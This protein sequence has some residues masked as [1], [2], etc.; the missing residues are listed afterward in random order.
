V[1]VADWLQGQDKFLVLSDLIPLT[2]IEDPHD[3]DLELKINQTVKQSDNTGNMHFKIYD[4]L[5]YL[6]KHITLEAGDI[7]LTG[8]PE[9]AGPVKEGD[10]LQASLTHKGNVLAHIE[11]TI[12]AEH[13]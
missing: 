7:I 4:Q 3:V 13:R 2:A 5:A 1:A 11:D 12:Q 8:T 10:L 6:S 9:G